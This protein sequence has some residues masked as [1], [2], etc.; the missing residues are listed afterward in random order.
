MGLRRGGRGVGWVRQTL[1]VKNSASFRAELYQIASY[2]SPLAVGRDECNT[3]GKF[4]A[5][6][7]RT[8]VLEAFNRVTHARLRWG[9]ASSR[10]RSEH[11]GRGVMGCVGRDI[12]G[13]R[14]R[15]VIKLC[16]TDQSAPLLEFA[17]AVLIL[18]QGGPAHIGQQ[19]LFAVECGHE[20]ARLVWLDA[21]QVDH[22]AYA[23]T[24]WKQNQPVDPAT[25]SCEPRALALRNDTR[26]SCD[27]HK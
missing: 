4:A 10:H 15:R 9:T 21:K 13:G 20:L 11:A 27:W 5:N 26:R 18:L 8:S 23:S 16:A 19:L 7:D 1:A 2:P 24:F 25:I 6:N 12:D 22:G 14:R 17:I 3:M